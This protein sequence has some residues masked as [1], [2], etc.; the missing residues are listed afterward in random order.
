MELLLEERGPV[1]L[2]TLNRPSRL[3]ALSTSLLQALE[4]ALNEV[5]ARP[6]L[7]AVVL[8]G[9]GRVFCAGADIA[10]LKSKAGALA[11]AA[12]IEQIQRVVNRVEALPLPVIAA[13]HGL[14]F[15]GGFELALAADLIVAEDQTQFALPEVK[16]GVI[17]GAGGTQRLPRLVGRNRAKELL[18]SGDSIDAHRAEAWGIVNRVVPAGEAQSEALSWAA[19]LAERAPVALRLAKRAVNRGLETSL[20]AGLDLEMEAIL[21]L[22]GTR[23]Q[24][25]GMQAFL[26]KR[27]PQF[28]GE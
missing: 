13:V 21:I 16:I 1:A 10:E 3:N 7:R 6:H 23:D 27:A 22:F 19:S 26:E 12:Y 9:A 14:A 25:E 20:E 24:K 28:M 17:P 4:K 15:G 11:A 5:E 18:F 8:A 2:L